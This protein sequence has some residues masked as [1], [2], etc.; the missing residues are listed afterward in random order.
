MPIESWN[1]DMDYFVSHEVTYPETKRFIEAF[2][3][4]R[5][6]EI[7]KDYAQ[8][9]GTDPKTVE[10]VR[11][12]SFYYAHGI[13]GPGEVPYYGEYHTDLR[14]ITFSE[15]ILREPKPEDKRLSNAIR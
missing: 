2:N 11:P 8:R 4:D 15:D 12:D 1:T 14:A 13:H 6:E 10:V 7:C 9:T 3:F 5:L